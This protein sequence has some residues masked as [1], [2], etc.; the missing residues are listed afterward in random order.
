MKKRAYA[1]RPSGGQRNDNEP[2]SSRSAATARVN[3]GSAALGLPAESTASY[4]REALI[5]ARNE[6]AQ[7]ICIMLK[8][9]DKSAKHDNVAVLAL[10]RRVR[11]I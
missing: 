5:M 9:G 7:L 10:A 11:G 4:G 3:I 2:C 6:Q 1:N 8:Y